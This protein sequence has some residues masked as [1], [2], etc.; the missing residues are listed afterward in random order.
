MTGTLRGSWGFEAYEGPNFR[1][2]T[3][4]PEH[5][6]MAAADQS[7]L[8]VGREDTLHLQSEM[9]VCADSLTVKDGQGHDVKT[10]WKLAKPDELEIKFALKDQ[11]AGPMTMTLKQFGLAQPDQVPLRAYS[12]AAHLDGF[13]INAGDQQ[14]VL[15][16]TRLDE[17][18]HF[19]LNG[20]SFVPA[21]L[22]RADEK[23]ELRLSAT[24]ANPDALKPDQKLVAHVSLKDGRELDLPTTIAAPRPKMTLVSKNM[25]VVPTPTGINLGSQ[26]DLPLDGQI[27]FLLKT[28]RPDK[29]TRTEKLEVATADEQFSVTLSVADGSLMLRDAETLLAVLDPKKAFGPSAFGPLRFRPVGADGTRGDWQPLATL[30]RLP[31]L[32]EIRCPESVDKPCQLTGTNLFLLDSVASDIQFAHNAPVPTGF[33]DST[34]SIPHPT[35]TGLYIKLRDDPGTV[36]QVVLPISQE[37]ESTDT[38]G[39]ALPQ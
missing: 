21:K 34:L 32:K 24:G 1:F 11:Q 25:Q 4:R 17:V 30:V 29:L 7:A 26:D 22:T 19:E 12:E 3:S 27:S 35:D 37:K 6:T 18:D 23:D 10:T 14:G 28:E 8:I 31:A 20:V 15:K 38:A 5:W 33:L 13:S 39:P 36:S 9:A 2:K 16:G